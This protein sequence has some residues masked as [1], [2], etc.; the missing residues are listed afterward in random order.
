MQ[1][2]LLPG[3]LRSSKASTPCDAK[4]LMT[5][6]IALFFVATLP[7]SLS[8]LALTAYSHSMAFQSHR[9][10]RVGHATLRFQLPWCF[11]SHTSYLL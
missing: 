1:L 11:D 3:F 7:V 5:L 8:L 9:Y 2:A 10:F 6:I 4:L